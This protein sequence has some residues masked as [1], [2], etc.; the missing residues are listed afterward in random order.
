V[1]EIGDVVA[2]GPAGFEPPPGNLDPSIRHLLRGV[3][4]LK[5]RLLLVLD[6]ARTTEI[7]PAVNRPAK[8]NHDDT[9]IE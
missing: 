4:Q 3:Y 6:T 2:L 1:D 7:A 9:K 8:R 5:N